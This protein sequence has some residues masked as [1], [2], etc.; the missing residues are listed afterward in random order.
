MGSTARGWAAWFGT[1][2]TGRRGLTLLGLGLVVL[3]VVWW[4]AT[5][6]R[7]N[8]YAGGRLWFPAYR[9]LSV[10]FLHNYYSA[11]LWLAGGD[12]YEGVS[13]APLTAHFCYA[14]V[15]LPLFAWCGLVSPETGVK[16]W[17]GIL[18]AFVGLAS[19]AAWRLRRRL[20]LAE[21]PLPLIAGCLLLSTPVLF[22]MERGNYDLL[23]VALFLGA[24]AALGRRSALGD[25]T[26]GCCLA[27]AAWVKV[28]PG[29]SVLGLLA[30]GRRRAFLA[31]LAAGLALGLAD[32]THTLAFLDNAGALSR[33]FM[34]SRYGVVHPSVH[35]L[36]GCWPLFWEHTRLKWLIHVPGWAVW[37]AAAIPLTGWVSWHVRRSGGGALLLPYF[38]WLTTVGTFLP[39]V[40]NDYNLVYLPVAVLAVW[41]RRD[42]V[43]LHVLMAFLLLHWQPVQLGISG[44]LLFLFKCLGVVAA[45]ACL[46]NR[47]REVCVSELAGAEPLGRT[48]WAVAA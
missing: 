35:T 25:V 36:A 32:L 9:L 44:E 41:D 48:A 5:L 14:P 38:C 20:G 11:R 1:W 42:P 40:S 12:P 19:W 18:A 43:W 47:A 7:G 29:L 22:A 21:L 3:G 26:A 13:G 17:T 23:V 15:V 30:L 34:P 6:R 45:G 46:V 33:D 4:V 39:G 8:L 28:Y 10:D 24:G 16:V 27:L 31:C 37:L 2:F